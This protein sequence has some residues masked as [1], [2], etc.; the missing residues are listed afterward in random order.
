MVLEPLQGNVVRRETMTLRQ[1]YLKI[2]RG[3][4]SVLSSLEIFGCATEKEGVS[5]GFGEKTGGGGREGGRGRAGG[6]AAGANGQGAIS[7][8]DHE[9][10]FVGGEADAEEGTGE[11]EGVEDVVRLKIIYFDVSVQGGGQ[12]ARALSIDGEASDGLGVVREGMQRT[13]AFSTTAEQ[14]PYFDGVCSG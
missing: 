4:N 5:A 10:A 3:R 1:L 8:P 13:L 6:G 9:L 14:I 11:S 2:P 12:Q 7:F